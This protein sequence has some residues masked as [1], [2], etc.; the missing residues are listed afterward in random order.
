MQ[1]YEVVTITY[2]SHNNEVE[3]E[4]DTSIATFQIGSYVGTSPVIS[5]HLEKPQHLV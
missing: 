4:A 2:I 1:L 3:V 5:Q